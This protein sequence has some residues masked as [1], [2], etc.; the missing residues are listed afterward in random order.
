MR[1]ATEETAGAA[2]GEGRNVRF[3]NPPSAAPSRACNPQ[4][5]NCKWWPYSTSNDFEANTATIIILL[6]CALIC[7]LALNTAIRW[8]LRGGRGRSQEEE[9]G[10]GEQ[11]KPSKDHEMLLGTETLQIYSTAMKQVDC[12][13]CLSEFGEGEQ[14]RVLGRCNHAFHPH[15]VDKWLSSHPSCPT[16]RTTCLP[17]SFD[18][19][20]TPK[21]ANR[22]PENANSQLPPPPPPP[23]HHIITIAIDPIPSHLPL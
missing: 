4:V 9:G 22:C 10:E 12:A 1:A 20:E 17:S 6:L 2:E 3:L 15:C 5:Q 7:A 19:L 13:I 21:T 18:S 8:F 14:V 16:C 11:Q 23:R